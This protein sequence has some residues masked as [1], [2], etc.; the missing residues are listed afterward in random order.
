M[1]VSFGL[2]F[3]SV[4]SIR[5]LNLSLFEV[6]MKHGLIWSGFLRIFYRNPLIFTL[7]ASQFFS[8]IFLK[9]C[10]I[11]YFNW[12]NN[13]MKSAKPMLFPTNFTPPIVKQSCLELKVF[14]YCIPYNTF[15]RGNLFFCGQPAITNLTQN[16]KTIIFH[17]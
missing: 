1:F 6:L 5:S 14:L 7:F 16:V 11:R 12:Q 17:E 13:N 10:H 8:R 15:P 3:G 2:K 4:K 9:V